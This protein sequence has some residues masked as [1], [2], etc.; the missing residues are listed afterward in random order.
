MTSTL[1]A[2]A[3]QRMPD[4][5]GDRLLTDPVHRHLHRLR[6]ASEIAG[7]VHLHQGAHPGQLVQIADAPLRC[8]V[9]RV[10]IAE[11]PDHRAHLV[12]RPGG[13]CLD[14]CQCLDRRSRVCGSHGPPRLRLDRDGRHVVRDGVVQLAG[15]LT[16]LERPDLLHLAL[17][18]NRA[19]AHRGPEREHRDQHGGAADHVPEGRAGRE[20]QARRYGDDRRPDQRLASG[21]PA[22]Q[23]VG[24][25]HDADHGVQPDLDDVVDEGRDVQHHRAAEA[26]RGRQQRMGTPP[27]QD[28]DHQERD[29]GG[30]GA[31]RHVGAEDRLGHGRDQQGADQGPVPPHPHR[32]V[33]GTGLGKYR[34][35][36]GG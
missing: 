24:Q 17:A 33:R 32:R 26:D 3:L 6:Q 2:V 20:T 5:V 18:C 29:H 9:D 23:R 21:S 11:H 22:V 10:A 4:R 13:L 19:V 35:D 12:Q 30:Q 36:E 7:A 34:A 1:T 14:H 27:E 16:A 31:P 8:V 15:E 28:R 25:Q